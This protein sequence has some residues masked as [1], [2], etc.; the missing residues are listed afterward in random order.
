[1]KSRWEQRSHWIE[2][3]HHI[4]FVFKYFTDWQVGFIRQ[5]VLKL[6]F[7]TSITFPVSLYMVMGKLSLWPLIFITDLVAASL[8]KTNLLLWIFHH[9]FV[10]SWL[11]FYQVSDVVCRQTG[12]HFIIWSYLILKI[13]PP[14][15]EFIKQVMR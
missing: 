2:I 14:T 3:A 4:Q 1:M 11:C 7:R 6:Y 9:V 15:L 8:R 10:L 12:R 13:V 5:C